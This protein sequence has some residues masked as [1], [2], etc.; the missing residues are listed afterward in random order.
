M[1]ESEAKEQ[2]RKAESKLWFGIGSAQAKEA[3]EQINQRRKIEN[4]EV[5]K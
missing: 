1:T 4:R 3:A 5:K 2:R